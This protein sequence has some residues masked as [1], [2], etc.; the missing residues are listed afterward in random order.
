MYI[1]YPYQIHV[2]GKVEGLDGSAPLVHDLERRKGESVA[3]R[4]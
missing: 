1:I 4:Y 2:P 3:P